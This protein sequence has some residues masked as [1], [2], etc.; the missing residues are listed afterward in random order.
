MSGVSGNG[1]AMSGLGGLA[2][3]GE[4]MLS[5]AD[6]ASLQVNVSAVFEDGF[7]LGA[8]HYAST[9]LFVS[10]NGLVSFGAAVNGVQGSLGAIARPFIAAFHADVDTRLDG[11]GPES[12]PVWVDIDPEAD[13]VSITWQEVGFYRRNASVTNTF[14]LQLYDRGEDG[15]DIVL[16]YE[17]I[18]WT[19][20][21]LEGGWQGLGGDPALIGWR[22][23]AFGTINGH[24]ASGQEGRL[25]TL[26]DQ[27]GNT[28]VAGLWVY[29]YVP[30][31]VVNGTSAGD[32]LAGGAGED[33]L[34]GGAGD[35]VFLGSLGADAFFGGTGIDTVSYAASAGPVTVNLASPSANRGAEA[36]GDSYASVEG[37]IGSGFGDALTGDTGAN[38]LR[39][40]A[41][42]DTL[43]GGAGNDTLYGG[44]GNDVFMAGSGADL[45]FGG[46]GTDRVDYA[47]APG[48]VRVDLLNPASNTGI[49]AGDRLHEIEWISGSARN[50]TL[51]GDNLANWL[52]GGS[53][54]DLLLGRGGADQ[55]YGGVGNDSLIGGSGADSFFGGSGSDLV[56]YSNATTAVRVDLLLPSSNRGADA[57]GDRFN[58]IE[59]LLGSGLNDTLLGDSSRNKLYGGAGHD[60][61][62][63]SDGNDTLWGG[64]GDDVLAGGRGADLLHGGTGRDRVSY[65][66]ASAGVGA[67][68]SRPDRNFGEALGDRYVEIEDLSGS[69]YHDRLS[70]TAAANRIYGGA[71]DD[72][73][74]GYGGADL[75]D[76]GDG[77]D[78]AS[79][80]DAARGVL[81][82]LAQPS[83]NTGDARG[84]RYSSVEGLQGSAH[85]DDLRGNGAANLLQGL[86]GNDTLM[87]AAGRDS[88]QGGSGAD[89]L[90]G[91]SGIDLASYADA[92]VGVVASLGSPAANTGD[93]RGDRYVSIEGLIGSHHADTLTGSAAVDVLF[94]GA[95]ND[96]LRG[97]AGAD[98]LD[99][100]TGLDWADYASA[101]KG[102]TANLANPAANTGDALGDRYVSVE[103]LRGSSFGD[104][105]YGD[106]RSNRIEG[107][108][109][110]DWLFGGDGNDRLD[111]GAGMDRLMGGRGADTF[112]LR[113]L[114]EGGDVILDYDPA[115]GD[116]LAITVAGLQRA[117][118]AVRVQTLAGQGAAG[119]PEALILHRPSGQVLF[120]LVDSGRLEDIFLR[121]GS[122][123]YDLL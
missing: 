25:L 51:V 61:I 32:T 2:G 122:V 95:G 29:R 82:D 78:L 58:S 112:V 11:E 43:R 114:S 116:A 57:L 13:V 93:A 65:G 17:S 86:G 21:D 34:Y 66:S 53:G 28:G 119:T 16:R 24:W 101:S 52:V 22:M 30:P 42:D 107:G 121:I 15:I 102:L 19:T 100:G 123:S 110:N 109:G 26:P 9:S 98:H 80:A 117:D 74:Q 31:K 41:G 97:G 76:G 64:V 5:R 18:G 47:E 105:L 54:D 120:T 90:N 12:G 87:G 60:Q 83:A 108:G 27:L 49:A 73:L 111:G 103:G 69:A 44:V 79:Y 23:A 84:D 50:D 85:G 96:V 68:L 10:T 4:I 37:V 62:F 36:L 35:D 67:D 8:T 94:G 59:D 118:L 3:Y 39:G 92:R 38:L 91:G 7:Q 14:Q 77:F 1:T 6:D 70:G 81:A 46:S 113:H 63:G 56:S 55:L 71:G 72:T 40:E 115:A 20:G 104:R 88:L 99:G 33:L 75:L 89:L 106:A 48:P 45:Y